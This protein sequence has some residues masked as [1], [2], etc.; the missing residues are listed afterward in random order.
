MT[1]HLPYS[2]R[3]RTH[4]FGWLRIRGRLSV[5]VSPLAF[6]DAQNSLQCLLQESCHEALLTLNKGFY[7]AMS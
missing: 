2:A 1:P 4:A 6:G 7:L 5:V 3:P